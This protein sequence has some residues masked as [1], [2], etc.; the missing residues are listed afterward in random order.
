MPIINTH[1]CFRYNLLTH[2]VGV[3]CADTETKTRFPVQGKK[4]FQGLEWVRE[5]GRGVRDHAES[6][7]LE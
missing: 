1:L 5:N 7:R 4:A 2:R 6:I 3:R